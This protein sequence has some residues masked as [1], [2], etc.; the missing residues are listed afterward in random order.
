MNTRIRN[1]IAVFNLMKYQPSLEK[2][3]V[4]REVKLE[5]LKIA[6]MGRKKSYF[7]KFLNEHK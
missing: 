6:G 5:A 2:E 1:F 7:L 4:Q 3:D